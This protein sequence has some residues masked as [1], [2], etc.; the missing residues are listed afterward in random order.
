MDTVRTPGR[1]PGG[2][3]ERGE[4]T[5][6]RLLEEMVPGIFLPGTMSHA[7][8][9]PVHKGILA[10]I[11]L[12]IKKKGLSRLKYRLATRGGSNELI[13]PKRPQR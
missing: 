4:K 13:V 5:G 2:G 7:K 1:D 3:G 10:R 12:R 9:D 6:G 11:E 8:K